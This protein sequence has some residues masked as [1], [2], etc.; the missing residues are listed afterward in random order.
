MHPA[1]S[2]ILFTVTAGLAQGLFVALALLPGWSDQ[3]SVVGGLL[4][5]GLLVAG[6]V[7]SVFHLGRPER[8]WRAVAMWRTSWL[9]RE[10]L[11]LPAFIAAVAA[12]TLAR[13]LGSPWAGPLVPVALLLCA[14]L[15]YCTAMIYA[16]LRFLQE[17]AHPLTIVN[18]TLI[19]LASGF[20]L[21]AVLARA[22]DEPAA[23]ACLAAALA[24]SLIAAA[25][26]AASLARNARLKPR[27]TIQSATGLRHPQVVQRAQGA[28]GGSFNTREFFHGKPGAW[29]RHAKWLA[30]VAGF[31]LPAALLGAGLASESAAW[32]VAALLVQYP[33]LLVERWLFF[34]QA[35]HP[36]NL[37]YQYVS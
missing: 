2:V 1:P 32:P 21:A 22:M 23:G 19:G 25:T 34:A 3:A 12:W 29:L 5:M 35:R 10:V 28:T 27:S 15:W 7:A 14:L 17:W 36:Q 6:L 8:A 37:Y 31:L 9:S 11:V 13:W 33:G 20:T 16:C 4:S 24:A 30:I 26:R 18:Y